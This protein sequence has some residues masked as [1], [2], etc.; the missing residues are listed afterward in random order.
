MK[1][2]FQLIGLSLLVVV[3]PAASWYFLKSGLDYRIESMDKLGTYGTLPEA[4]LSLTNGRTVNTSSVDGK[5]AII[6]QM[7]DGADT[8]RIMQLYRQ[9]AKRTDLQFILTASD[10]L[11]LKADRVANLWLLEDTATNNDFFKSLWRKTF[12]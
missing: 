9:F 5:M 3:L 11:K 1:K 7:S 6:H 4:D 2:I 12:F 8:A 10:L